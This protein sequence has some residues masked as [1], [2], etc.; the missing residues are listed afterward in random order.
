[1]GIRGVFYTWAE[2]ARALHGISYD[3]VIPLLIE[4]LKELDAKAKLL[5]LYRLHDDHN[6]DE[7]KLLRLQEVVDGLV[8]R[9]DHLVEKNSE[10]LNR[11]DELESIVSHMKRTGSSVTCAQ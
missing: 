6:D 8:T 4:A 1:M 11:I 3:G 10:L 9:R 7:E 2:Q 5:D